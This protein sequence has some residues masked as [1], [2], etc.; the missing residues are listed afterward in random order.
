MRAWMS[1]PLAYLKVDSELGSAF[2]EV[3]TWV[4]A[5]AAVVFA[6]TLVAYFVVLAKELETKEHR[7][8]RAFARQWTWYLALTAPVGI[9]IA[10]ELFAILAER[11]E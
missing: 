9:Q 5:H 1:W 11:G 2:G 6:T 3:V 4:T 8:L 10:L 7:L